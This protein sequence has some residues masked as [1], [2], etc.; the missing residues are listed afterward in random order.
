MAWRTTRL[1]LRAPKPLAGSQVDWGHNLAKGLQVCFLFNEN[2]GTLV[3][4][5][6]AIP[7]LHGVMLGKNIVWNNF[8]RYTFANDQNTSCGLLA[9]NGAQS[10][11]TRRIQL[12]KSFIIG[13]GRPFTIIV[14]G[15]NHDDDVNAQ[16]SVLLGN[17]DV[18]EDALGHGLFLRQHR[19]YDDDGDAHSVT[20][21][22]EWDFTEVH[23]RAYVCGTTMFVDYYRDAEY[24]A[25]HT[26]I[27]A[28]FHLTIDRLLSW[29]NFLNH[30]FC[31]GAVTS[32]MIWD[33]ALSP[34]EV[35]KHYEHPYCMV[36]EEK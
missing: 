21:E 27:G 28:D 7:N 23:H 20:T 8:G 19:F 36:T 35:R 25:S 26:S 6:G 3:Q 1:L 4:S 31:G 10:S 13:A 9:I 16:H 11:L 34:E 33:R 14:D 30:N 5:I 29:N 32:I 18:D 2:K 12:N 17:N 24:V 22:D 15:A